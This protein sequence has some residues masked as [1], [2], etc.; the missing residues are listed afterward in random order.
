MPRESVPDT[1]PDALA[2]ALGHILAGARKEWQ[3]DLDLITTQSNLVIAELRRQ[4]GE[5]VAAFKDMTATQVDRVTAAIA[6]ITNGKDADPVVISRMVDEKVGS[7][8]AALPVPKDGVS[9]TIE[10]I[11][12]TVRQTISVWLEPLPK[13]V[14]DTVAEAVSALPPAEPG[15]DADPAETGRMVDAAVERAVAALDLATP[16]TEAVGTA[17]KALPEPSAGKDA[18]PE[19]T[20]GLVDEAVQTAVAAIDIAPIVNA[21]VKGAVETAV[22][23]LPA[24]K[25]GK[26]ADPEKVRALVDETVK[27]AVAAIEIAPV[28]SAAVG[29]AIEALPEPAA[30]KDADPK[31]TKALVDEAVKVAVA[32][33][34]LTP[35]VEPIILAAVEKAVEAIPPAE[36]GK[37]ADMDAVTASISTMV[38]DAVEAI[39]LAP[40]VS[41]AVEVAVEALP[42]AEPGKD[43]DPVQTALLVD[44]AVEKAVSAL[45]PAKD[46]EPGM[47]DMDQVK[48][49]VVDAAKDVIAATFNQPKDGADVDM[50]VV[51]E[52]I[53]EEVK[54][55]MPEPI[56]GKSVT[57]D[58]VRP[59][60]EEMVAALPA[61]EPGKDADMAEVERMVGEQ[62]AA[63]V[64]KHL[65]E[66]VAA[67]VENATVG[68]PETIADLVQ[69]AF[70]EMPKPRDGADVDMTEVLARVEAEVSKTLEAWPQP[71]DG[72]S[73][74]LE[75]VRP[76][77]E[78]RVAAEVK[79][80]PAPKDGVGLAGAIIDRQGDLIVTFTDGRTK[81]LGRVVGKDV[82]QAAV[83]EAIQAEFAKLPVPKDGQDGVGFDDMT[84]EMVDEKTVALIFTKGDVIKETRF[85][86]AVPIHR[87][88]WS[89]DKEYLPGDSVSYQGHLFFAKEITKVRPDPDA[90]GDAG[91]WQLSVK[92]GRDG[93]VVDSSAPK[94]PPPR[95]KL[96]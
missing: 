88:F 29:L 10:D 8:V 92:R 69:K 34:E 79:A 91:P 61:P 70:D 15:R 50:V 31:V 73:V 83:T 7:A 67:S 17:V 74:T 71:K 22:K 64:E 45:P 55:W 14:K 51:K 21:A 81:E 36:P 54:R 24:A 93:K 27:S 49:L 66:S 59:L 96:K 82:D 94:P 4:N 47:V 60:L 58:D 33:I 38:K 85:P 20:K 5:L 68:I 86:I 90:A 1:I 52:H 65:P 9:L 40:M 84:V 25:P 46:G 78:E 77:I 11:T 44:A 43:A 80:L 48:A 89:G 18:D 95:V 28:V 42:P 6:G 12:P 72:E 3:K 23:A 57:V 53:T 76:M 87:G 2:D 35:I 19:V 30:G 56:A 41:A 26:D 37:D 32:S 75:Q 63:V 62:V 39:D 13:M 16:I